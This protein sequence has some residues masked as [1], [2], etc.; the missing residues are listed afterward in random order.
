[1][2]LMIA[3]GGDGQLN[4]V[5]RAKKKGY[6]VVVSDM[7]PHCPG[8]LEADF[9]VKADTFSF[10]ET[11]KGAQSENIDAILTLGTDQP[12]L[13]C[14]QVADALRIPFGISVKTAHAVTNK[15]IM[16]PLFVQNNIPTSRFTL[17][18]KGFTPQEI[19][20]LNFPLVVKPVDSQ[21][22]RGVY[23]VNTSDELAAFLPDVLSYSRE[24]SALV[25]EFYPSE[26]V[27][28][29]GWS[30]EG[31]F[32]PITIT[33]RVTRNNEPHIGVCTSH[34]YPS[35]HFNRYGKE[36][37]EISQNIVTSFKIENGPVYI[38]MLIGDEGIK[39]NEVA[40]RIGGAYEDEF[41]PALTGIDILDL[42]FQLAEKGKADVQPL[43]SFKFPEPGFGSVLLFFTREGTI[44]ENGNMD[45]IKKIPG[46]INGKYLLP[47]GKIIGRRENSS[48]RA[49]FVAFLSKS[50]AQKEQL[51]KQIYTLLEIRNIKGENIVC[52][53]L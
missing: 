28:V 7:N 17:I 49:G 31:S 29:S 16:K 6:T 8:A 36:I 32:Y 25:E 42:Q 38:Q 2:K 37:I 39:V 40:S 22:Q 3:G 18:Q 50:A 47:P 43:D 12:V 45:N 1:M 11:L 26:E 19:S 9:F 15:R 34:E 5:R 30:S 14:A 46:V 52:E 53:Y 41:I 27:T 24:T 23:K 48:C 51:R 20:A 13:T 35:R 33:D 4:A 10:A 44:K 21:G